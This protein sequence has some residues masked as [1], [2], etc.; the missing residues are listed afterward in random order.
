M[1]GQKRTQRS[2]AREATLQPVSPTKALKSEEIR[3]I[4]D[5]KGMTGEENE[6][7][8]GEEPAR[9]DDEGRGSFESRRDALSHGV[10]AEDRQEEGEEGRVSKGISAPQKV[11]KEERDEHNRT[12]TPFRA[13]CRHCVRG[14]GKS[15]PHCAGVKEEEELK[16]PKISMD[17]FFM[18]DKDEKASE[19]PLLV[20]L[21]ESTGTKYARAV[22]QKG[23][24]SENEL[25]WLV[26]DISRELK[27]WGHMGGP[28]GCI[29]LKSD[30]EKPICTKSWSS[31]Q[32]N[33]SLSSGEAELVAAVKMST[34][35]IGLI[36]LARE[37][38]LEL[39]GSVLVDSSAALG[40]VKRRGNGRLR[41]IKI[42][43]L[44]V[45]EKAESGELLY[46]KVQSASNMADLLTK[47]LG[48]R[49]MNSHIQGMSLYCP[50]GRAGESLTIY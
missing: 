31:T 42:G 49:L 45:Q 44:W 41:H 7:K 48:Q 46:K 1:A 12:H 38:D 36:Q 15:T 13:W 24:G 47:N 28:G 23:L 21:D 29:I 26:R 43:M 6:V 16:V 39:T 2:I 11:S 20:V 9:S 30:N 40:V 5:D 3:V 4:E 18:S 22:G 50:D 35:L 25:D 8:E 10:A 19:N 33:I 32:K 37:W 14:R 17:Y 27:S 34:E